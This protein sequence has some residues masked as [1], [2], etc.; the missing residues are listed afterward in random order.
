MGEKTHSCVGGGAGHYTLVCVW[1]QAASGTSAH[2]MYDGKGGR[3]V[4]RVADTAA[5]RADGVVGSKTSPFRLPPKQAAGNLVALGQSEKHP[6]NQLRTLAFANTQH[7]TT[8][9]LAET[10]E[11]LADQS[12]IRER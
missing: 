2:V 8:P 4:Q 7:P 12:L 6:E 11:T 9:A 3:G 5:L 1:S 10:W